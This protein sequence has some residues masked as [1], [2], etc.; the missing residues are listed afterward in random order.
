M[1][2]VGRER[3]RLINAD[4]HLLVAAVPRAELHDS[5]EQ[6]VE[7]DDV[8]GNRHMVRPTSIQMIG[9][10]DEM[11]IETHMVAAGRTVI[12]PTPFSVLRAC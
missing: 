3:H 12:I 4:G 6:H 11:A 5:Y 9:D 1:A 7:F 10:A 8:D 2:L